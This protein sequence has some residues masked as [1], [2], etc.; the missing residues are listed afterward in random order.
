MNT[1]TISYILIMTIYNEIKM[2]LTPFM[3][4]SENALN[5]NGID[6][7]TVYISSIIDTIK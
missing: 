1:N 3:F 4:S 5:T 6:G 7:I 2:I